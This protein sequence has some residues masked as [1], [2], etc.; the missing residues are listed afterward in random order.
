MVLLQGMFAFA[1]KPKMETLKY[2]LGRWCSDSWWLV[3]SGIWMSGSSVKCRIISAR[4]DPVCYRG[5]TLLHEFAFRNSIFMFDS[6]ETWNQSAQTHTRQ[7]SMVPFISSASWSKFFAVSSLPIGCSLK[8]ANAAME[9]P[10]G[11]VRRSLTLLL[12][13]ILRRY[14]NS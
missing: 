11:E 3:R 1:W 6:I 14:W 2:G 10:N 9:H 12:K 13:M 8:E 7:F 5:C 4:E